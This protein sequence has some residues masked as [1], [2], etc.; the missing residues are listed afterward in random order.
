[1]SIAQSSYNNNAPSTSV[2][3]GSFESV[4]VS[5]RKPEKKLAKA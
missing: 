4:N 2:S 1:V 5:A 3:E